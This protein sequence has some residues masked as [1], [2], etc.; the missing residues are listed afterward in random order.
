M[1]GIRQMDSDGVASSALLLHQSHQPVI[2]C[3]LKVKSQNIRCESYTSIQKA[4]PYPIDYIVIVSSTENN[5]VA[6]EQSGMLE[7]SQVRFQSVK[8]MTLSEKE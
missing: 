1:L 3:S 8:M 5:P 4:W 7:G 2:V 6:E